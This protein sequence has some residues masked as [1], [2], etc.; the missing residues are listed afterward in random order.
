[1]KVLLNAL[2]III[3]AHVIITKLENSRIPVGIMENL[4]NQSNQQIEYLLDEEENFTNSFSNSSD[5]LEYM[6][7]QSLDEEPFSTSVAQEREIVNTP[8]DKMIYAS[9][10][11]EEDAGEGEPSNPNFK[12]GVTNLNKYFHTNKPKEI[13]QVDQMSQQPC[14]LNNDDNGCTMSNVRWKYKD[15]Q[16]QNGGDFLSGVTAFNGMD[17]SYAVY[18][19]DS[20]NLQSK[21]DDVSIPANSNK[22]TL[23]M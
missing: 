10:Y 23:N 5:L 19:S 21:I 6:N 15:E 13:T 17:D 4:Y 2:I 9:N 22:A 20:L 18:D 11:Y 8:P 3:I 12:P 16:V 7:S 14:F 1:M